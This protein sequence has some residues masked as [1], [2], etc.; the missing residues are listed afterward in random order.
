MTSNFLQ[1]GRT[2]GIGKMERFWIITVPKILWNCGGALIS[3]IRAY[4]YLNVKKGKP[5]W[6][7]AD[8]GQCH[9]KFCQICGKGTGVSFIKG[10]LSK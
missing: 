10:L 3:Y 5:F 4:W 8:D 9:S 7:D 2:I 6:P 1:V